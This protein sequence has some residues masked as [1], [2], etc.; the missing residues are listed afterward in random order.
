MTRET[1]P[2][3]LDLEAC[4]EN[5]GIYGRISDARSCRDIA[6]AVIRECE[7]L[8]AA[9]EEM[10]ETHGVA[11]YLA[12]NLAAVRRERD[13]FEAERDKATAENDRLRVVL[14]EIAAYADERAGAGGLPLAETALRAIAN[15]ARQAVIAGQED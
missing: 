3:P 1:T 15:T 14:R 7:R 4:R 9:A 8:R 6:L 2:E 10:R 5:L 12:D 11:A 13:E